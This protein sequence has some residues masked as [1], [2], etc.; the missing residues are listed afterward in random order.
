MN[1]ELDAY[2][3]H[4]RIFKSD[5]EIFV[6]DENY[7]LA[8]ISNGTKNFFAE[9]KVIISEGE[10]LFEIIQDMPCFQEKK[11]LYEQVSLT[12]LKAG[13]FVVQEIGSSKT[14]HLHMLM[15]SPILSPIDKKLIGIEVTACKLDELPSTHS[16]TSYCDLLENNPVNLTIRER[17][18]VYLKLVG[19]TNLEISKI[20]NKTYKIDI[21]EKTINNITLQQIYPKLK[22]NNKR[23]LQ[24]KA[25]QLGFDKFIPKSLLKAE[26]FIY[27]NDM[28]KIKYL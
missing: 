7:K 5:D 16:M 24:I 26:I 9:N 19:K 12:K 4:I 22:V 17:E 18:I 27:I 20:I 11:A 10:F 6:V 23:D 3:K 15:L 28:G 13:Y 1:Q 25:Q 2:C 8:Y 21:T 14:L